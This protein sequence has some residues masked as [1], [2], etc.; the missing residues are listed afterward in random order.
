MA[1]TLTFFSLMTSDPKSIW[2]CSVDKSATTSMLRDFISLTKLSWP[3]LPKSL[4]TH[5]TAT[6]FSLQLV[7]QVVGDFGHAELLPERGAEDPGVSLLRNVGGFGADDLRDF[8]LLRQ[9]HVHLDRAGIDRPKHDIGIAVENLLDLGTRDA[10]IALGIEM[11]GLDLAPEDAARLVDL[12]DRHR[13]AIPP[14]CSGHRA[15]SGQFD[16]VGNVDRRLRVDGYRPQRRDN[17]CAAPGS[18]MPH[19]VL[20]PQTFLFGL[21]CSA[22]LIS[23]TVRKSEQPCGR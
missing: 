8:R 17:C 7:V 4:L 5:T 20:P 3:P 2:P 11:L 22:W 1:S 12:V 23:R 18:K 14:V 21:V 13:G 19:D 10:R 15:R 6:D 9:R 16:D